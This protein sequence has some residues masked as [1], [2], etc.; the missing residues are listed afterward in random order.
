MRQKLV[1]V[2]H[3]GKTGS[4]CACLTCES[5]KYHDDMSLVVG[6]CGSGMAALTTEGFETFWKTGRSHLV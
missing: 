5:M 4:G 1:E 6:G 3:V 2:P